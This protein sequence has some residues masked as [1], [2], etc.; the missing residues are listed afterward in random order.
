MPS[1]THPGNGDCL[2]SRRF[3]DENNL[4]LKQLTRLQGE[5]PS[6]ILPQREHHCATCGGLDATRIGLLLAHG[7]LHRLTA[8]VELI[9]ILHRTGRERTAEVEHTHVLH[10]ERKHIV[11]IDKKGIGKGGSLRDHQLDTRIDQHRDGI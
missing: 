10:L 9:A 11:F 1:D 4:F 5:R 3:V 7:D 8:Q 6:L 2:V